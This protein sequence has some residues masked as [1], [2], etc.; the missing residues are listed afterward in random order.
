MPPPPPPPASELMD[1]LVDEVLLRFPPHEPERLVRAALVCKRWRRLIYSD[2]GFR[3][4]FRE[5]HRSPP[6][7]ARLPLRPRVDIVPP[8]SAFLTAP[9]MGWAWE[10]NHPR[11]EGDLVVWDPITDAHRE[12]PKLPG[13]LFARL[14]CSWAAAVLCAAAG[15]SSCNH[16][17]CQGGPF[18]VVLVCTAPRETFTCVYCSEA[19][20]WS[21]PASAQLRRAWVHLAPPSVLVESALYFVSGDWSRR[22]IKV[23]K[24]D[25]GTKETSL[26][27]L[28]R[29]GY[30]RIELLKTMDGGLA[31]A[32]VHELKL[33]VWSRVADHE[34]YAG[35]AQ[36][37]AFE[38]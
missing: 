14:P 10:N 33:Y 36:N 11:S 21:E 19:G 24:H 16:V 8:R 13:H 26:I 3:R 4:R 30:K 5:F 29:T 28:L 37:R 2:P 18:L 6:I 17:D 35:W 22:S 34:G 25:L 20:A 32:A 23:L 27:R 7:D 15:S 1:D 12:L 38:L 9:A 31:F